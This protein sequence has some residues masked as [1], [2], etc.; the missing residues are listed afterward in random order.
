MSAAPL[1]SVV[2]PVLNGA[3]TIGD[4][5]TGLLH[6]RPL[7][8]ER[9]ILVVDN[10]STDATRRVVGQFPVTLLSEPRP[11]PSAARNCG[12][13]AA[14]GAI[15]AHLDADTLP[16]R[17]W[18]AAIAAAFADPA[19]VQVAGRLLADRPS[20]PAA[21]YF[22]RCF[23]DRDEA[24]ARATPFPFASSG[25]MAVRREALLAVG[26]WDEQFRVS[27]DVDLSCRLADRF[28][29]PI[30]Y[31]AAALAFV[32]I[33]RTPAELRAQAFKYG[34][35]RAQLWMH[36]RDRAPS[37]ARQATRIAGGLAW[38]AAWPAVIAAARRLGR[39]SAED[40]ALAV[41]H[42]TWNW[43]LWRGFASMVRHREWRQ[44]P[45]RRRA[46]AGAVAAPAAPEL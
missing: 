13:H 6:Q 24:N 21:R 34:Q 3:A 28:A 14:R 10:G 1:V 43:F 15:V 2:I 29:Q 4:T 45:V 5:L 25:N 11:G 9:E 42:R 31:Q 26:G 46:P 41:C 44:L 27:Q 32:R 39:A 17:G 37:S 35:G 19:V 7:G 36:Y 16:T 30:R 38:S 12:L 33:C 22:A 8:F 20:T 23:L 40:V 18:L